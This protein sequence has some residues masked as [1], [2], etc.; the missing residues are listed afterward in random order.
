M[1]SSA[2]NDLEVLS[3]SSLKTTLLDSYHY[4]TLFI[5]EAIEFRGISHLNSP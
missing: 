1:S 4:Y 3:H 5:Y 2:L